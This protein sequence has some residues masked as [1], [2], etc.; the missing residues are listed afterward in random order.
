MP[1][2][3]CAQAHSA[4]AQ[5]VPH[6]EQPQAEPS[7]RAQP[8][9]KASRKAT[10]S[11]QPD[12]LNARELAPE[13]PDEIELMLKCVS[14]AELNKRQVKKH[15]VYQVCIGHVLVRV[16]VRGRVGWGQ[17]Y[18]IPSSDPDQ[19]AALLYRDAFIKN[20][21]LP[22]DTRKFV[23]GPDSATHIQHAFIRPCVTAPTYHP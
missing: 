6:Q 3:S 5:V 7:G 2:C 4:S 17:P 14:E 8:G 19:V 18:P 22:E 12:L 11:R 13:E 15:G 23:R 20:C 9:K 21:S 10:K 1:H 16:R